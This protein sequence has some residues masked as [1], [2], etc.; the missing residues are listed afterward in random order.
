[1]IGQKYNQLNSGKK[2][3]KQITNTQSIVDHIFFT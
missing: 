2:N 1:M 3:E